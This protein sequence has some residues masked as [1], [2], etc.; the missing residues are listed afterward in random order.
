MIRTLLQCHCYL[1]RKQQNQS[2]STEYFPRSRCCTNK[3]TFDVGLS[4]NFDNSLTFW[5]HEWRATSYQWKTFFS[6]FFLMAQQTTTQIRLTRKRFHNWISDVWLSSVRSVSTEN[7]RLKVHSF[8]MLED[9]YNRL[10][11]IKRMYLFLLVLE[12]SKKANECS[13]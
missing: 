2:N 10:A 7:I 6:K 1:L 3:C 12:H 11:T 9:Y 5:L 13:T 4:I 8:S